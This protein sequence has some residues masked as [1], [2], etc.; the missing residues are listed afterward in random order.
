M[1]LEIIRDDITKIKVDCIV[2]PTDE[3]YSGLGGTDAKIYEASGPRLY[4]KCT[5]L[6]PLATSEVCLTDSYDL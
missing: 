5:S 1:P 6:S 3:Y 2:N 4:E